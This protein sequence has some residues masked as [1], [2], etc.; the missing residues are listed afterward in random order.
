MFLN[1]FLTELSQAQ[2]VEWAKVFRIGSRDSD[3]DR[4]VQ[5][6]DSTFAILGRSRSFGWR[7]PQGEGVMGL[8]FVRLYKNGDTMFVRNMH[9]P[10]GSYENCLAKGKEGNLFMG[11]EVQVDTFLHSRC[12]I[13]KCD[14]YGNVKWMYPFLASEWNP[15]G[16]S[17]IIPLSDGGCLAGGSATSIFPGQGSD[18]ILLRFDSL[19][20]LLW[21]RQYNNGFT[22][23]GINLEAYPDG[24]Y[25]MSG[26]ANDSVWSVVVDSAGNQVNSHSWYHTLDAS[27]PYGGLIKTGQNY[28]YSY[29]SNF[30]DSRSTIIR[31]DE[32]KVPLWSKRNAP[33]GNAPFLSLDGG[34]VRFEAY[35]AANT[36]FRKYNADSSVS[37]SILLANQ[38]QIEIFDMA[39]DGL[40][41]AVLAGFKRNPALPT[42]MYFI[43]VSNVGYPVNPLA[44]QKPVSKPKEQVTLNPYPNPAE[45]YFY[46][47]GLKATAKVQ[48]FDLQGRKVSQHQVQPNE[49]IPVWSLKKGLYVWRAEDGKKS[50]SGK[51]WKE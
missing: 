40:G 19:G 8:A 50:W 12:R 21:N 24:T 36:Y 49:P 42:D 38:A 2:T 20:G 47:G 22:T 4:I 17:Q 13:L 41:S 16:I 46:L 28:Y 35:P 32:N 6:E 18:M 30:G 43:K 14:Y 29:H 26:V 5:L 3:A 37:W 48:L 15:V 1:L 39:Y 11:F 31:F 44:S 9:Q 7:T 27:I 33:L 23:W 25:H 34:Y 10:I 51:V 45:R